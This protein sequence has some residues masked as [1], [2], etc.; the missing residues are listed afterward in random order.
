MVGETLQQGVL[1]PSQSPW[2]EPTVNLYSPIC[3][4][5]VVFYLDALS[6]LTYHYPEARL[7]VVKY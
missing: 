7:S 6:N 4:L 1:K 2:D 5:K 3:V